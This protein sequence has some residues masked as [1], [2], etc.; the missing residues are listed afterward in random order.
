MDEIKRIVHKLGKILCYLLEF[1][2]VNLEKEVDSQ[3]FYGELEI[4]LE[5]EKINTEEGLL[6]SDNDT[7][8]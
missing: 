2:L 7:W 5:T 4:K 6:V 3:I 1:E 8:K